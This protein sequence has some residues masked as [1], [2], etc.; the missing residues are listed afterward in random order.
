VVG[1][2]VGLVLASAMLR[3]GSWS[4]SNSYWGTSQ[5]KPPN[6]TL[7][8]SNGFDQQSMI[9]LALSRILELGGT[10]M[11]EWPTIRP[12]QLREKTSVSLRT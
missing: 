1:M 11:E 10:V 5:L 9:A 3:E 4:K 6:G 7:A 8:A 2:S 12:E